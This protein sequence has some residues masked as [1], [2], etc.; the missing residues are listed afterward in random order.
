M[1]N[2][3]R[4]MLL[5]VPLLS[6]ALA[7]GIARADSAQEIDINSDAALEQFYEEV[8]AGREFAK[9][10]K[11][12]LIFP[13]IIKAGLLVGGEYGEGALRINGKSV[14][15]YSTAAASFGFQFGAQSKSVVLV[16]LT[17]KALADFRSSKGW[18]AGVNG[19]IAVID[20]SAAGEIETQTLSNPI[21]AFVF[22]G[23][24]L[25]VDASLEGSKYT[26][27]DK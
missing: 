23:K 3:L 16:F 5:G 18:E 27:L 12:V 10:A 11:G 14:A 20:K 21:V 13:S 1:S 26:K 6:L 17:E 22:A 4:F 9:K 2:A 7:T 25:M 8:R 19:S 24:G 15:Y